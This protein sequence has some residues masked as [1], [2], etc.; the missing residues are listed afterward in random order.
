MADIPENLCKTDRSLFACRV[1]HFSNLAHKVLESS[2]TVRLIKYLRSNFEKNSER[3]EILDVENSRIFRLSKIV[4]IHRV[5]K[6]KT[7]DIGRY[8]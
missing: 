2:R 8:S 6:L 3:N 4:S 5:M 7:I 1:V